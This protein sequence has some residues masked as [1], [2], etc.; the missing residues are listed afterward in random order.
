MALCGLVTTGVAGCTEADIYS[1]VTPPIEADR[2]AFSGRVCSEDPVKAQFPVRIVLLVDQAVGPMFSNF[3]PAGERANAITAFIQ[4]LV[5]KPKVEFAIVSYAGFSRKVA[6]QVGNFTRNIGELI[7]APLGLLSPQPCSTFGV[8][9]DH[10]A[11]M[12]TA[13]TLIEGDMAS[14]QPGVRGLTQYV[15]LHI[16]GGPPEPLTLA[17]DCCAPGDLQCVSDGQIGSY[18]CQAQK[19]A[20]LVKDMRDFVVANGAAGLR[21]HTYH[22]AANG[23]ATDGLTELV[24]QQI[25]FAGAGR[26]TRYASIEQFTPS[27]LDVVDTRTPLR[28]KNLVVSNM[29]AKATPFGPAVDS[30]ADGLSDAE[31]AGIGTS[32]TMADTDGDDLSDLIE[33]L[34]GYDA[35]VAETERPKACQ[36]I[37]PGLDTDRDGLNDCEEELLGTEAS[38]VDSDG[39]GMPDF[40]ELVSGT[41]YLHRD[42]SVDSDG[43][44]LANGKEIQVHTDPRSTDGAKHLSFSYRYEIEDEG[45]VRELVAQEL[46][47][48][49]GVKIV[50]LS[51]GTT[52]GV[53]T[54]TYDAAARTLVWH[55]QKDKNPGPAV[56]IDGP[57]EYRLPSSSYA[58]IQNDEGRFIMVEVDPPA[59]SPKDVEEQVIIAV[60]ERQC[61]K[62]TVRNVRLMATL[63][64]EGKP[65]EEGLNQVMLYLAQA[66]EDR[67]DLPGP[68]RLSQ[69]PIVYRPPVFRQ[70]GAATLPVFDEEFVNALLN[71]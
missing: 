46:Q 48:I 69:I 26:Y 41:D 4:G 12:N 53:G 13:L 59:F 37:K 5:S 10:R 51:T 20:A 22:F 39:D 67:L 50:A 44:G 45:L 49:P 11:G 27:E 54:V 52:P 57:G 19:D 15:I 58:P 25:A 71:F 18:E 43:D 21:Y 68:F 34:L 38:L 62:Y 35:L 32:P 55:D 64:P 1:T 8:C 14:Q 56:V 24:M 3:D 60:R 65:E 40:L 23:D 47:T 28:I 2:V 61:I 7:A 30:D 31:E 29:N 6:P 17:A 9:R 42:V 36:S 70:P 63:A 16:N 66:P 33:T